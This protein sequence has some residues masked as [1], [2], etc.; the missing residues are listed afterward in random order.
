MDGCTAITFVK[1][2]K[3]VFVQAGVCAAWWHLW[4]QSFHN[5]AIKQNLDE[6][7]FD[8]LYI[9][10]YCWAAIPDPI[11]MTN[12]RKINMLTGSSAENNFMNF[13][14]DFERFRMNLGF[15]FL[16]HTIQGGPERMQELWLLISW[17][18]SMK[19]NCFLFYLVEHSFSNKI[20]PWSLVLSKVSGL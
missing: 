16:T 13:L 20:T 1:H 7:S 18:S 5:K 3:I 17:T 15:L 8:M 11:W 19:Q 4:V 10:N 14:F 9:Q 12:K 2:V 6:D